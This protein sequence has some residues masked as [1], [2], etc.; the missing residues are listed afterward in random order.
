MST[1]RIG[2]TTFREDDVKDPELLRRA[3]NAFGKEMY[4][5]LMELRASPRVT[6]L[7]PVTFR[8]GG[9]LAIGTAPFPLRLRAPPAVKGAWIVGLEAATSGNAST[10][11]AMAWCRPLGDSADAAAN[12]E[13]VFITGLA[14][15]TEYVLRLAV[16]HG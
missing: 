3:L 14:T 1:P 8:T 2:A 12:L 7:D 13:V 4:E 5:Q 9:S 16:A 10:N 6:I 11:A 15:S